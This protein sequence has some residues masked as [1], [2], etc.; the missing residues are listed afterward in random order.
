MN[1]ILSSLKVSENSIFL[2]QRRVSGKMK[3]LQ[4]LAEYF[5]V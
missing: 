2:V 3:V 1:G 4:T 5:K